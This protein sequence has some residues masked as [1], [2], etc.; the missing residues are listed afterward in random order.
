MS[1]Y[2][3]PQR[4]KLIWAALDFDGT[5]AESTWTASNPTA[6]PGHPIHR[7]IHKLYKLIDAGYKIVIH[8][9]RSW[10][11]YELVE[12]WFNSWGI[13]FDKIVC[14]KLLADIYCDDRAIYSEDWSWLPTDRQPKG[15]TL[16]KGVNDDT[17][18]AG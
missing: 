8:T 7:N 1:N 14:G 12:S 15:L 18:A 4:E 10:A 17:P 9:S 5:I 3:P 11:D 6:L 13:H 2:P 16:L